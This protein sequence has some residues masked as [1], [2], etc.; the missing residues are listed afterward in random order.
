MKKSQKNY[1]KMMSWKKWHLRILFAG[2][3]ASS[4]AALSQPLAFKPEELSKLSGLKNEIEQLS[5]DASDAQRKY[6]AKQIEVAK[7]KKEL[8][9]IEREV[10]ATKEKRQKLEDADSQDPGSINQDRLVQVRQ[11]NDAAYDKKRKVAT[12]L[13]KAISAQNELE[14]TYLQ[15]A[16]GDELVRKDYESRIGVLV[17]R[18]LATRKSEYQKAQNVEAIGIISCAEM[19]VKECKEKSLRE[20]ERQA[21]ERGSVIVVDS[22]TEINNSSL[23][24]DQIRSATRGKIFSREIIEAKFVNN[25]T[26]FQTT[27]RAQVT[28]GLGPEL[29]AEMRQSARMDIE[30]QIGGGVSTAD[31]AP[32]RLAAP[33]VAPTATRTTAAS[34]RSDALIREME[35]GNSRPL[36]ERRPVTRAP[37]PL[38]DQVA[39]P[40]KKASV[41]IPSF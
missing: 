37:A 11:E 22:I 38:P 8:A 6:E 21:I 5:A 17:E 27:I 35:D 28:P 40:P 25:D 19:P 3:L 29:L 1:Q 31:I 10:A 15:K 13:S 24:K 33:V 18:V 16:S 23:T 34:N 4:F 39:P 2:L 30:A 32:I 7:L 41:A 26:A 9:A 12:Q 20:S 36:D 14:Q